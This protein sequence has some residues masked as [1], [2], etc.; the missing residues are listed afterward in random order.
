MSGVYA[1]QFFKSFDS[2]FQ[3][4]LFCQNAEAED[5]KIKNGSSF[6][7]IESIDSPASNVFAED[8]FHSGQHLPITSETAY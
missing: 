1:P 4:K 5:T 3:L 8:P 2:F 7:N 6:A